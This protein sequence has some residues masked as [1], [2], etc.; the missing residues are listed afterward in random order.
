MFISIC[1]K[2]I[3]HSF[4]L[5][6]CAKPTFLLATSA[7]PAT[8]IYSSAIGKKPTAPAACSQRSAFGTAI[9]KY[10]YFQ[11]LKDGLVFVHFRVIF[12]LEADF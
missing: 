8:P 4:W 12:R 5:V 10:K 3:V 7:L 6:V 2:P 9:A 11:Q 1:A